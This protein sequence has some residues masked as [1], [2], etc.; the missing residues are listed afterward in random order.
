MTDADRERW[1]QYASAVL[2]IEVEPGT[3]VTLNGAA[4]VDELPLGSPMFLSTAWNP[5]GEERSADEN[6]AANVRMEAELRSLSTVVV[7][8]VGH[9]T[10][11]G[12]REEGFAVAGI[13]RAEALEV[14][15]RFEQEAIY[16]VDD[17]TVRIVP[18]DDGAQV[19]FPRRLNAGGGPLDVR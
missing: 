9:D 1:E 17:D 13:G 3:W 19:E 6:A 14:A 10:E 15:R 5:F 12:Y 2:L 8:A 16:E 4:A 7:R 11:T 18:C